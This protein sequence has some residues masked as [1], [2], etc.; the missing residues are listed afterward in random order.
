L[1][2]AAYAAFDR[3]AQGQRVAQQINAERS[4]PRMRSLQTS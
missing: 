4:Y 3:Q 1:L 2:D